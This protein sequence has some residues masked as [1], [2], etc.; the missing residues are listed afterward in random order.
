[1][2]PGS[3]GLFE[4]VLTVV[5]VVTEVVAEVVA[6]EDVVD[7][8][9]DPTSIAPSRFFAA[10]LPF[11]VEVEVEVKVVCGAPAAVGTV[12]EVSDVDRAADSARDSTSVLSTPV[13]ETEAAAA[14][15]AAF[16]CFFFF[17]LDSFWAFISSSDDMETT[18]G[19]A[20]RGP[21][22]STSDAAAR[23]AGAIV[24]VLGGAFVT[25]KGAAGAI[26]PVE[27][28]AAFF[29]TAARNLAAAAATAA[30]DFST[31]A[32]VF[33]RPPPTSGQTA[34]VARLD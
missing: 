2:K 10:A 33:F 25:D 26:V 7:P 11:L 32:F 31:S 16:L 8:S 1:V 23:G 19:P 21:V 18:D 24:G 15:A 14:A 12:A 20:M 27:L 22:G 34:S 30:A 9:V 13:A 4:G 6:S 17:D 29:K 5:E 3:N 28:L